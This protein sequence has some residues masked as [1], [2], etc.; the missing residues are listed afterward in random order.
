M[1][2]VPESKVRYWDGEFDIIKSQRNSKGGR[3]YTKEDIENFRII[4]H[5]LKEKGM[6]IE[7]AIQHLKGGLDEE[8]AKSEAVTRLKAVREELLEIKKEISE[9]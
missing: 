8:R 9:N 6:T 7:G 3:I 5:L 1:L 2:D 4:Y